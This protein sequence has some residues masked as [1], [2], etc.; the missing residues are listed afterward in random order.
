MRGVP[1]AWLQLSFEK[2]R[3]VAALAGITFAVVLMLMELGLREVL[4]RASARIPTHVAGDLVMVHSQY[5]FL[6]ALRSFSA[7]RLYSALAADGVQAVVPVYS[8][9]GSWKDP[10][11]RREHRIFV[12]AAPASSEVL[13]VPSLRDQ[14]KKLSVP[15]VVIFDVGSRP[16]YGP[17]AELYERSSPV[18]TEINDRRVRVAG[19][20]DLGAT[21]G[22]GGHVL[23]SDINFSRLFDRPLG[24]IDLGLIRLKPGADPDA[25]RR[26][27]TPR[28]P[29]DVIV[30]T[31]GEFAAREADYWEKR[32]AIGFIFDLGAVMG[33][34]VGAVIVYQILYTD[35]V[36]HL[37]E[38]ATLKAIGYRDR[39][40]YSI[41][42]QES[43]VL[44]VLGF[45]PGI[46]IAE[47][48]YL[49]ARHNAHVPVEMT[50][51][52]AAGVFVLTVFMC[53]ASGS[54]AMRKLTHADP[55]EVF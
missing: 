17:I 45:I 26:H 30:L 9:M 21:F 49:V 14:M 23:T 15:D 51:A 24:T 7:R 33:L 52:R 35:V 6:Y 53:I 1:L 36:D 50:V 12:I 31:R 27:I 3:F 18:Y 28:I 20:F 55:A 10:V 44:S 38:Y 39:Y 48:L 13:D 47:V 32:A 5:E 37:D 4:Y 54:I 41:V 16:E 29:G 42:L 25:V 19:L 43:V 34:F 46:A 2:R 40:L 11:T 8:Q 22:A